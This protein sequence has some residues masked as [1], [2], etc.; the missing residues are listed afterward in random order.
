MELLLSHSCLMF[1]FVFFSVNQL[2]RLMFLRKLGTSVPM[3]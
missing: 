3:W 1:I 2:N